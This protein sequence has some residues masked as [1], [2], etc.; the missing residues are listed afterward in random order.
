[1]GRLFGTN[2]IRGVPGRELTPELIMAV[3]RAVSERL[4]GRIAVG[5]DGRSSSPMMSELMVSTLLDSGSDVCDAGVLPTPALQYYAGSGGFD[6]GVMITASHNPPEFNGIK[7]MGPNGTEISRETEGE[8]E[9]LVASE[10]R[11]RGPK[12]GG[13]R[14]GT[15]AIERYLQAVVG[16]ALSERIRSAGLKVV[17]DAGNGMQ[18]LAVPELLGRLGCSAVCLN[19][20]VDGGFP[21][22]GSEPA[23]EKLGGL[24]KAVVDAGANLGV[25]FDG[26]GD[27][28][29]FCDEKGTVYTG[30]RSG[31]LLVDHI[32][33]TGGR[34][35]VVTTVATSKI[36]EWAVRKNDSELVL[37]RVG[38]VDVTHAMVTQGCVAGLEENGGFFYAPHQPVRDGAMALVLMLNV[39]AERRKKLSEAMAE[40]PAF[41]QRKGKVPSG[42]ADVT[43][44]LSE[45]AGGAQVDLTDGVKLSF[46]DGSW[47]LVRPSGTEPLI[48]VFAEAKTE[49][50][51]EELYEKYFGI[52]RKLTTKKAA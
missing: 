31:S 18:A 37:T 19:C 46:G 42:K 16:H 22:R 14:Q 32:L 50:R 51:A 40:L 28:S 39:L 13:L 36:V 34:G 27:R 6:G 12:P 7:V 3:G 35:K 26:D 25:A 23:L 48:R 5:R 30:D 47:V 8:I 2:G 17:V 44:A 9:A 49:N 11:K 24:S 10:G 21:G 15:D 29:V 33:S 38:S 1:M 52:V 20:E 41:Y 4:G 43:R 45:D